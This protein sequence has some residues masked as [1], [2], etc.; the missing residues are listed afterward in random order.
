MVFVK[1]KS[2]S[3]KKFGGW[4]KITQPAEYQHTGVMLILRK[5][6]KHKPGLDIFPKSWMDALRTKHGNLSIR[7]GLVVVQIP[8]KL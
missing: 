6:A 8:I 1:F 2:R 4:P 3:L 7:N 5:L